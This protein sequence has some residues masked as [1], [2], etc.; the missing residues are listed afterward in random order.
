[1]PWIPR[2]AAMALVAAIISL[3]ACTDSTE[4]RK[5]V[6]AHL[7]AVS[8][9]EL[10]AVVG[11]WLGSVPTVRATD[12]VGN[13]LSGVEVFFTATG[14]DVVGQ[15]TVTTDSSGTASVAHWR[16]GTK[17][18]IHTV[19]AQSGG[20]TVVFR[21]YVN[22]GPVAKLLRVAG[23]FQTS[24]MRATLPM[25]LQAKAVDAFANPVI[26]AVVT[27]SVETGG[28]SVDV[29]LGNR[30][31]GSAITGTDGMVMTDWTLGGES[32]TQEVRAESGAAYVVFTALACDQSSCPDMLFVR[33]GD[34]Y[35]FDSH[36]VRQL[37]HDGSN[38]QPVWSPDGQRI[39]FAHG[40]PRNM[41]GPYVMNADG[42]NPQPVTSLSPLHHPAWSP[43]GK[44][45]VLAG[46]SPFCVYYC[47]IYE[48]KL[49]D[50]AAPVQ[51]I[52]PMGTDPDWSPDGERIAYV[53]LSGDDGYHALWV[54]NADGTGVSELTPRDE[55]A[56]FGPKWSPDGKR[57]AVSKCI[58]GGCDI[59]LYGGDPVLTRLTNLGNAFYPTWSP[60][61]TRIAFT[62]GNSVEY[63]PVTG[64]EPIH[65]LSEA[66]SPSWHP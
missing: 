12:A 30:S 39:A 25:A 60:D 11:T 55:G 48:L 62:R 5:A 32:E 33:A 66:S 14:D 19:T 23:D 35:R 1:M 43:D 47:S 53:S 42:S 10:T 37:T 31:V 40:W 21:A 7:D 3:I 28:G 29:G 18:G 27:F 51:Q 34:I 24:I 8:P 46:D 52:A 13:P 15:A 58:G 65:L 2:R 36:G 41:I 45:L 26:G 44:S 20:L 17:A 57:I 38:D 6:V 56:L 63:V 54:V 59:Y 61:G 22:A 4:P 50:P 16:V 9:I 49:T 64:G